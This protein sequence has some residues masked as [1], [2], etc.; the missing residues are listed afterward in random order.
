MANERVKSV[1]GYFMRLVGGV[2]VILGL[3]GIFATLAQGN[4]TGLVLSIIFIVGGVVLLKRS[5]DLGGAGRRER[6]HA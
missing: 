6:G 1:G 2:A 3:L 5:P 4:V